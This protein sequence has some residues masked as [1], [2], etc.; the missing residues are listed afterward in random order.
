MS[1]AT[2]P[3]NERPDY[4]CSKLQ[5][6]IR[7]MELDLPKPANRGDVAALKTLNRNL[8]GLF[9]YM[10]AGDKADVFPT[11]EA[12]FHP[13]EAAANASGILSA[14]AALFAKHETLKDAPDL[15]ARHFKV[16]IDH[17][18]EHYQ[19]FSKLAELNTEKT[20]ISR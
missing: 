17:D 18:G 12:A 9:N 7:M 5:V 1:F 11:Q 20:E 2:L 6:Q 4:L 8:A 13:K 3:K 15:I 14:A 10:A 16:K 19:R